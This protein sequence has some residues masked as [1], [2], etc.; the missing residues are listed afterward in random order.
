MCQ[1]PGMKNKSVLKRLRP[2]FAA[3]GGSRESETT[4]SKNTNSKARAWA[5]DP[6]LANALAYLA[7]HPG[8]FLFPLAVTDPKVRPKGKPVFKNNLA[9][10]SNKPEQLK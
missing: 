9:L 8:R 10:A 5:Q 2:G 7:K 4:M 1:R 3:R 6:D